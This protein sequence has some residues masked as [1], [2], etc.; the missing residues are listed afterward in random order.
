[1]LHNFIGDVFEC[2]I[3]SCDDGYELGYYSVNGCETCKCVFIDGCT[4]PSA[5]P[6]NV[7]TG[8]P[9]PL[10]TEIPTQE[11]TQFDCPDMHEICNVLECYDSHCYTLGCY[12]LDDSDNS[13]NGDINNNNNNNKCSTYDFLAYSDCGGDVNCNDCRTWGCKTCEPG[14]YKMGNKMACQSCSDTYSNCAQCSDWNGCV[15]CESGYVLQ[16]DQICQDEICQ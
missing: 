15:A 13:D 1:M 11:P 16:Y 9:T 2:P 6:S 3:E 14:Y 5:S 8:Q 10:P 7:P 12:D 4:E